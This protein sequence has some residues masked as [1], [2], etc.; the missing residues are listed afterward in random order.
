MSGY[1]QAE[2]DEIIA[3]MCQASA[4]FYRD[5]TRIG[6]H[7]FIEFTGLMN[8]FINLCEQAQRQGIDF[9]DTSVHGGEAALPMRGHH[10]QYLN[11][12][13][14]CIYGRSLAE[15]GWTVRGEP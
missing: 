12:K 8:E 14:E 9:L 7:T 1:T 13:L 10:R 11:E 6:C 3:R 5:A 2:R 15:L 4:A